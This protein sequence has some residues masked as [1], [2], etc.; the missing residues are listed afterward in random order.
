MHK[1]D[2]KVIRLQKLAKTSSKLCQGVVF[3]SMVVK[4]NH[5]RGIRYFAINHLKKF[6][7]NYGPQKAFLKVCHI[8]MA[9][10]NKQSKSRSETFMTVTYILYF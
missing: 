8:I 5:D 4:K 3:N 10:Q 9:F 6:I 1:F 2:D 7:E